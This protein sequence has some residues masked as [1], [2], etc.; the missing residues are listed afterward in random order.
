MT[1]DRLSFPFQEELRRREHELLFFAQRLGHL[2]SVQSELE[3]VTRGKSFVIY[4][5]PMWI[6]LLSERDMLVT[7]LASWAKGFYGRGGFLRR[8]HGADL[9][10][11]A[12]GWDG[13]AVGDSYEVE[14]TRKWRDEAFDRLFP[15]AAADV[16]SQHADIEALVDRLCQRFERLLLDRHENRAHK[17]EREGP[18]TTAMLSLEDVEGYLEECQQLL[19]DIRT[20]SLNS[21]FDA[22]HYRRRPSK[23]DDHAEDV[24]DLV[25]CG[26]IG[27][28]LHFE[29]GKGHPPERR[30]YWQKRNAHYERLHEWHAAAG[31][32]K[33]LFNSRAIVPDEL[34]A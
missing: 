16:P 21:S 1:T 26:S 33:E 12:R 19:A 31:E 18:G 6:M 4:S 11:L 7:D 15:G 30:Y 22:H 25:L 20:L 23:P 13:P 8:L 34:S 10:A 2:L 9:R 28:I 29:P 5:E 32:T 3:R 27:H 24:V 14:H 17:Y